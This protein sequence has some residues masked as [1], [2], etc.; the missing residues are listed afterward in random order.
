MTDP[1]NSPPAAE[2]GPS[3]GP[4][5]PCAKCGT[6]VDANTASWS[7][8]G[9]RICKRCQALETIDTG[10]MRAASSILGGGLGAFSTGLLSLCINPLLIFSVIAIISGIGTLVMIFRHP[11]YREKMGWRYPV[12][13]ITSVL[14]ILMGLVIPFFLMLGLL[15]MGISAMT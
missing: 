6:V 11:E 7:E 3:G 4:T 8:S 15:G 12:A 9:D 14:G 1:F 5:L 13:I 10:D 2:P